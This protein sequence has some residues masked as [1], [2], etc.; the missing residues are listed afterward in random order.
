MGLNRTCYRMF[1]CLDKCHQ[2]HFETL[3]SELL[4]WFTYSLLGGLNLLVH[5]LFGGFVTRP[6]RF[7]S[8]ERLE[9]SCHDMICHVMSFTSG[10]CAAEFA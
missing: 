4:H 9:A 7:S 10:V 5:D 8:L 6:P 1:Y 2:K 3:Q